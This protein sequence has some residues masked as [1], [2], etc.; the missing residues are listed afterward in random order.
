MSHLLC[1]CIRR[2]MRLDEDEAQELLEE[3][4][5]PKY[6]IETKTTVITS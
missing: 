5:G 6:E 3:Y 4:T 1:A 2:A